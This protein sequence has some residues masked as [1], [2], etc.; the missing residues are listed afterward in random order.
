[1]QTGPGCSGRLAELALCAGI[2]RWKLVRECLSPALGQVNCFVNI[3]EVF[4]MAGMS[5]GRVLS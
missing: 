5:S 1:M 4:M 3:R 2:C